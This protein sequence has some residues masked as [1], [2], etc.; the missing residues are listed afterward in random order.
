MAVHCAIDAVLNYGITPSWLYTFGAPRVGNDNFAAYYANIIPNLYRV[1]YKKDPVPNLPLQVMHYQHLPQEIYYK[2]DFD[3][4]IVCDGSG[5][6]PECQNGYQVV[7][8][9]LYIPNHLQYMGYDFTLNFLSCKT[10][11]V[12]EEVTSNANIIRIYCWI[13]C[14]LLISIFKY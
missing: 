8:K 4:Y 10:D 6:D 2:E 3:S 9:T 13:M 14:I 11:L 1:T 5:E 12:V 7:E